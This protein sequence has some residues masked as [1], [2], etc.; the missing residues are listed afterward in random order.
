[1]KVEITQTSHKIKDKR[2]DNTGEMLID[3]A[4]LEIVP[5]KGAGT[6]QDYVIMDWITQHHKTIEIRLGDKKWVAKQ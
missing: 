6:M 5:D 3:G 1:M 4:V 2:I